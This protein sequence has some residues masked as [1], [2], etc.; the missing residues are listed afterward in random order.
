M[1]IKT[2]PLSCHGCKHFP[3]Q[4]QVWNAD[5]GLGSSL[6]SSHSCSLW[7]HYLSLLLGNA[8]HES[9]HLAHCFDQLGLQIL[10]VSPQGIMLVS[11]VLSVLCANGHS[12]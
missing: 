12:L 7:L 5:L 3:R 1:D 10:Q 8:D 9:L 2:E 4:Q 6:I 11:C